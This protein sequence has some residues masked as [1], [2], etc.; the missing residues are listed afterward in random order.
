M[1]SS[2]RS[3]FFEKFWEW[4]KLDVLNNI[5]KCFEQLSDCLCEVDRD[6]PLSIDGGINEII[7][8]LI[9]F[10]KDI[11][12]L[13]ESIQKL[14]KGIDKNRL[15][16]NLS[17][18]LIFRHENCLSIEIEL[19]VCIDLSHLVKINEIGEICVKHSL[20]RFT[21]LCEIELSKE[22]FEKRIEEVVKTCLI[23]LLKILEKII[24]IIV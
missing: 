14:I 13:V 11:S 19:V 18:D 2:I 17:S 21:K 10:D 6:F 16:Y 8:Y 5:F 20:F 12:Q 23:K 15:I 7:Q 3:Y 9:Y 1:S 4:V 22:M 24:K